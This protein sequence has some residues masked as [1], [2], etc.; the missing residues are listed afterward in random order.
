[1]KA[2]HSP[3]AARVLPFRPSSPARHRLRRPL[4]IRWLKPL[5]AAVT[6]V[7]LP[8]VAAMWLLTSPGFA[9]SE[10]QIET[11]THPLASARP[12]VLAAAPRVPASWIQKTLEP[13][14]GRNI[15]LLE[16]DFV[17]RRL[18]A[19]PWVENVDLR[20]VL[21]HSLQLRVLERRA[22]AL[23][24]ENQQLYYLDEHGAVIAPIDPLAPIAD[25]LV[26]SRRDEQLSDLRSALELGRL[27]ET[28]RLS[29][30]QGLSEI[31]IVNPDDFRIFSTDLP[32]VLLV[33]ADSLNKKS[34]RLEALLPQIAERYPGVSA[35]DLRFSR[36]IIVQPSVPTPAVRTAKHPERS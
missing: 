6:I 31:E 21:P 7:G 26:I 18:R 12:S 15:W 11:V 36:R 24:N 17:A 9:L 16:L 29:W 33:R 20:K 5:A 27:I 1:M 13:L 32:F 25:L 2:P 14:K 3:D 8:V 30:S 10:L 35:V 28:S 23:L 22:V 19:H 4:W 34:R